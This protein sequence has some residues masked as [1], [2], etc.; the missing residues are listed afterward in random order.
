[1]IWPGKYDVFRIGWVMK[2]DVGRMKFTGGAWF[3]RLAV[4]LA[5]SLSG[6]A[7]AEPAE[8]ES[9]A[10]YE[11][12]FSEEK[13]PRWSSD[14]ATKSPDGKVRVHGPFRTE[15]T[16]LTLD[17]LPEHAYVVLEADVVVMG[18]WNVDG[19]GGQFSVTDDD[20]RVIAETAF[21]TA[22]P[23]VTI[24]LQSFPQHLNVLAHRPGFSALDRGSVG[25]TIND[26][27]DATFAMK[28]AFRHSG[29]SLKLRFNADRLH[30]KA[31][32]ALDRV[33][34]SVMSES[35]D[36][37]RE[38]FDQQVERLK[39]EDAR[40]YQ[41]AVNELVLMGDAIL[42]WV[43][44][45][46]TFDVNRARVVELVEDLSADAFQKREQATEKLI[47]LGAQIRPVLED[48]K[49]QSRS[50]EAI[51]RIDQVIPQLGQPELEPMDQRVALSLLRVLEMNGSAEAKALLEQ[52]TK[53]GKHPSITYQGLILTDRIDKPRYE[54]RRLAIE[55]TI[56]KG[57]MPESGDAGWAAGD[58]HIGGLDHRSQVHKVF[59]QMMTE[60]Q[61]KPWLKETWLAQPEQ[62]LGEE[63]KMVRQQSLVLWALIDESA[64]AE[65]DKVAQ[66]LPDKRWGTLVEII[67]S[68]Q[69]E[70]ADRLSV[71][72]LIYQSSTGQPA[73]LRRAALRQ[74]ESWA[75]QIMLAHREDDATRR[76]AVQLLTEVRTAIRQMDGEDVGAIDLLYLAN[77][78]QLNPRGEWSSKHGKLI[79]KKSDF[80][81]ITL[82]GKISKDAQYE[83]TIHFT[84]TE[85]N[86]GV[87][88]GFPVGEHSANLNLGGWGG[89]VD[90]LEWIDN[91]QANSNDTTR[92]PSKIKTGQLNRMVIRVT[93]QAGQ[94]TVSV[95]LNDANYI[96]W[97]GESKRLNRAPQWQAADVPSIAIGA[98][99]SGLEVQQVRLRL[100]KGRLEKE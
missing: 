76:Q 33:K 5:F 11:S 83:L 24:P 1:M 34:V 26:Y 18:P 6:F 9:K 75:E 12:T 82:P 58:L 73:L 63:Q 80:G 55:K 43:E 69:A 57:E 31:A 2:Q 78:K 35:A 84:R 22:S 40:K 21:S 23:Y 36:V 4:L 44:K 67:K 85:G 17:D 3:G 45:A 13:L 68:K 47:A 53:T 19:Q 20:G 42:P 97:T 66:A 91:Q 7:W 92:N 93:E 46:L 86:D 71:G 25:W 99:V 48:L 72:Q 15:G 50:H 37:T 59:G 88:I 39:A 32:W 64:T 52:T 77:V 81:V 28:V 98:H 29:E 94:H 61:Q 41:S 30:N 65:A 70:E 87:Y 62:P 14:I 90:G 74:V 95:K 49:R 89:T 38:D 96:R 54:A 27:A 100:I 51:S 60:L 79:L 10:V 16:F 56:L 8:P